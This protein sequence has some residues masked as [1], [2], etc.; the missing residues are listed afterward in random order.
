MTADATS[1][2]SK[3][4]RRGRRHPFRQLAAALGVTVLAA[5]LAVMI[6]PAFARMLG[7]P[8][9]AE[10][11]AVAMAA[12]AVAALLIWPAAWLVTSERAQKAERALIAVRRE[13]AKAKR[14]AYEARRNNSEDLFDLTASDRAGRRAS[15]EQLIRLFLETSPGAADRLRTAVED[16]DARSA[17]RHARRL[18]AASRNVGAVQLPGLLADVEAL[19]RAGDIGGMHAAASEAER[20]FDDLT[21]ALKT[22]QARG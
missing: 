12:A 19:A 7:F 22:L 16:G 2:K 10:P 18:R 14:A 4:I 6:A 11:E 9:S 17:S 13:L 5:V 15:A 21:Q 8:A 1:R 20:A 3:P